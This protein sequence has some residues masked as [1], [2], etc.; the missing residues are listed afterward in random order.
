[1]ELIIKNIKKHGLQPSILPFTADESKR[2]KADLVCIGRLRIYITISFKNIIKQ[3][4]QMA[5]Q[6]INK[7]RWPNLL[8]GVTTAVLL[9]WWPNLVL[10]V[11]TAVNIFRTLVTPA[12]Q[13]LR[14]YRQI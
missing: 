14:I 10:G 6:E 7:N 3:E 11:T 5:V 8:H 1:M 9:Y 13:S 4:I 2:N 12:M